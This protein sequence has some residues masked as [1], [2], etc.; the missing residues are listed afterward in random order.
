MPLVE[1]DFPDQAVP[2]SWHA[3]QVVFGEFAT[4]RKRGG[5]QHKIAGSF[6]A[7]IA[8][9]HGGENRRQEGN[10]SPTKDFQWRAD[11]ALRAG[12]T[13]AI[14]QRLSAPI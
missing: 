9:T 4:R 6:G 3:Q 7:R 12:V 1:P 8:T 5:L 11:E 14:R 2:T 10:A 13:A